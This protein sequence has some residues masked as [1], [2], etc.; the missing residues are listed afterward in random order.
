LRFFLVD[1]K[2][3][4]ELFW[5]FQ[6]FESQN[7]ENLETKRSFALQFLQSEFFSQAARKPLEREQGGRRAQVPSLV[8]VKPGNPLP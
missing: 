5:I 3:A 8:P 4:K 6:F 2:I 1:R 7:L